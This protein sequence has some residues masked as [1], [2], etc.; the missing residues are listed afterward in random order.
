MIDSKTDIEEIKKYIKNH[1]K[2]PIKFNI[3]WLDSNSKTKNKF[4]FGR[5]IKK[6]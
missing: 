1:K 2:E 3:T 6:I 4:H 5:N